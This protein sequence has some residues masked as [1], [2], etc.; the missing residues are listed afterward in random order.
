VQPFG[1]RRAGQRDPVDA[2]L[3]DPAEHD[4]VDR[5]GVEIPIDGDLLDL[6][7]APQLVLEDGPAAIGACEQ[8][9]T[10][11]DQGSERLGQRLGAERVGDEV[12]LQA[13]AGQGLGGR[14]ANCGQLGR[15]QGAEIEAERLQ[16]VEEMA[17]VVMFLASDAASSLMG[18]DLDVTGGNLTGAYFTQART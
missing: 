10:A 7:D 8:D 1:D 6:G 2:P 9:A 12:G 15:T 17:D 3:G 14:R 11:G 5:R 4:R 16:A 18:T 13:V